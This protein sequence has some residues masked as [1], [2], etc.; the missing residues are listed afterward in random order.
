LE[1][2]VNMDMDPRFVSYNSIDNSYH[3]K[4]ISSIKDQGYAADDVLW[5]ATEKM[6]GANYS[7]TIFRTGGD[8]PGLTKKYAMRSA[9]LGDQKFGHSD[10]VNRRYDLQF[11]QLW[12]VVSERHPDV[13]YLRLFGEYYGGSYRG[14]PSR[15]KSVQKGV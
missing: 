10:V 9:Y 5:C 11:D 8:G 7:V 4:T 14:M 15:Y 3:S 13:R 2:N 12:S 1:I 6:H